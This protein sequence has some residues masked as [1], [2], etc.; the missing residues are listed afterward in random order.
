[1]VI[2]VTVVMVTDME[3]QEQRVSMGSDGQERHHEGK[4]R[5]IRELS[6]LEKMYF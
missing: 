3:V 6:I 5:G 2:V 1:M 4:H